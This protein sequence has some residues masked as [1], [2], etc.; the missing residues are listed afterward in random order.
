MVAQQP[1][2]VPSGTVAGRVIDASGNPLGD[3]GVQVVGTTLGVQTGIDGTFRVR[4]VPAGTVTIQARRIGYTPKSITGLMLAGGQTLQ[5][6]ISLQTSAAQL[7]AQV[8]SAEAERGTVSEAL[9]QQR[10]A[11]GVVSS[12]TRE[13][14][15]RSPDADAAQAV[16]RVSGVTVQDGKYVQV[17][18]LGERY[19]TASLN[20][21]RLPSPEPERK[22][23]PLDLFPS[24]LIQ[25]VT[26]SKTFTPDQPGDFSGAS[27]DIK[28]R[29]FPAERQLSYSVNLGFNGGATGSDIPYAP[30]V[31]G[32]AL[33]M[34]G[35]SRFLP[36]QLR[37]A[38]NLNQAY[39]QPQINS[40]INSFRNVWTL[41]AH[42]ALP[43]RS[44]NFSFGG[45]DPVLGQRI[46]YV[47]SGTY[48]YGEDVKNDAMRA[49]VQPGSTT[50]SVR[51]IDHFDGTIGQSSVLWGGIVNLSTLLGTHS[52]ITW[53]NTY[54][55][56]ADNEARNE[57][58]ALERQ[59]VPV[60]VERMQYVERSVG[61]TQLAGDH[62]LGSRNR[63]DWSATATKVTRDEPDRS[64]IVYE[65]A[66]DAQ[67]REVLRWFN[68]EQGAVRT[69]ASLDESNF[70]GKTNYELQIG[71]AE[72]Q[73][74]VKVGGLVR[75][76]DRQ[77]DNRSFN[78]TA[79]NFPDSLRE[80]KPEELFGGRFTA[81]TST[82]FDLRALSQGGSYSASDH[83]AAGYAMADFGLGS[84]VR[85]V[86]G[87][88]LEHSHVLV[89]SKSTINQA[90]HVDRTY[91]DVLPSLALNVAVGDNS[92][93]RLS[94][95][96]T[97]A[98]PE[99]REQSDVCG[100]DVLGA[101]SVCGNP[102]LVR[103]LIDN[104]DVRWE[105]YPNPGEVFSIALFAK[106]FHDPI[107]RV[108]VA[109]ST[110]PLA[111]FANA[112]GADNL[113]VELDLRKRLDILGAPLRNFTWFANA[114]VMDSRIR[115]GENRGS[116]TNAKRRMMGQ[117]PY[118]INTGLT[119]APLR[120]GTSATLLYNRVGAR[121]V[122]AGELP[123]PDVIEQPRDMLDFSFR[124]PVLRGAS[125]RFDAKNLLDSRHFVSQGGIARESWRT[126]RA[127]TLGFSIQP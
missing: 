90:S 29:E 70:E 84:R 69:F 48:S 7:T 78:I 105:T 81:P 121:I 34:A 86:G 55:R 14:I 4:N 110:D 33:A 39:S 126:G 65:I 10:N 38:G 95:S 87:A 123:L 109:T 16:Q 82:T 19:T 6:D 3:V 13:Q 72:R 15:T 114:T 25:S 47:L 63:I 28:T 40:F 17:R 94:G 106:R 56:N 83:L 37:A 22:V 35:S 18:G 46:G 43:A 77:A 108:T 57:R 102:D 101:E 49:R 124:K 51:E 67:N 45:N 8:V 89:D 5:V 66:R 41:P 118:V 88:R 32:E 53:N 111:T 120:G 11:V 9:D 24:S 104:V 73:N 60:L 93:L 26:T 2:A 85:L 107:E 62:Q 54:D 64:Q 44:A 127:F 21:S 99:Y 27:V 115:L 1:T 100:Y 42:A 68:L 97:L 36:A 76:T 79:R 12:I 59:G 61:S 113:G 112:K 74:R 117:A 31:G 122:A 98:R 119:H 116:G 20:G 23:V 71:P 96:R 75:G 92:Q 50:G 58:G 103:T 125:L 91:S 80:L 30:G 52:K